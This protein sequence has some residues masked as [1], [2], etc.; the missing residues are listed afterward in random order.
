MDNGRRKYDLIPEGQHVKITACHY[1]YECIASGWD[2]YPID[3]PQ[4]KDNT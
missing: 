3:C 1:L 2:R 4:I